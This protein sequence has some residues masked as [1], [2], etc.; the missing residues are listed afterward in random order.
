M[1][2][3]YRLTIN[4]RLLKV[5][6]VIQHLNEIFCSIP[7]EERLVVDE[8]MCPTNMGLLKTHLSKQYL[9]NKPHKWG[10]KSFVMCCLRGIV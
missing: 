4:E 2:N 6:P 8:M 5:R 7:F 9:S 10:Y 3:T 1:T